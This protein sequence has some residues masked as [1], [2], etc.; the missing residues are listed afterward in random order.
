MINYDFGEGKKEKTKAIIDKFAESKKKKLDKKISKVRI[1]CVP[2]FLFSFFQ[3]SKEKD[4]PVKMDTSI[5]EEHYAN[6]WLH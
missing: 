2:S 3:I 6:N 5:Y 1:N 4:D